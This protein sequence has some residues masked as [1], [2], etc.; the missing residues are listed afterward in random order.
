MGW[1]ARLSIRFRALRVWG[2]PG[3]WSQVKTMILH[4]A[5]LAAAELG[6]L[7]PDAAFIPRPWDKARGRR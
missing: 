6:E 5:L 1:R 4:A 3:R 2:C 7:P